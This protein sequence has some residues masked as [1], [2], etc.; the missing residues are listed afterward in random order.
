MI[1][2]FKD[3]ILYC[4]NKYNKKVNLFYKTNINF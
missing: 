3:L 2:K 4:I 1:G